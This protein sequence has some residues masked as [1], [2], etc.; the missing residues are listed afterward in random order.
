[1][2]TYAMES[3]Q[4]FISNKFAK[5]LQTCFVLCHYGVWSVD[6]CGKKKLKQF[7]IRLQNNKMWKKMKGYEYFCNALYTHIYSALQKY[8]NSKAN[9]F[10]FAVD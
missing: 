3:F 7:N 6:W 4:F 1:M 10:I 8:W 5:M 2:N 9:S